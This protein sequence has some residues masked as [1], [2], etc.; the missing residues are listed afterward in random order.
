ME[1]RTYRGA[2]DPIALAQYLIDTWDQR[3]TAAQAMQGD[4]G[5]IVQVGQRTGGL[6]DDTPKQALTLAL[7]PAPEGLRVTMSQQQ[8]YSDSGGSIM[9]GGL[10][11]FFPF[12]FTW[13]LGGSRDQPVDPQL[14]AQLWQS[15][16]D[17]A[18]RSGAAPAASRPLPRW[19]APATGETVRL[20][21]V[22][23]PNCGTANPQGTARCRECGTFLQIRDC[24]Q[25][26]VSNPATANFCMR[27]GSPLHAQRAVGG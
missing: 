25:C 9:V 4:E 12:F 13:P 18:R 26:G 15:I 17:Y 22:T 3:D 20:D 19:P 27:C 7:E 1:Q 16:D 14:A 6:F 11:G 24:P 23:C 2:S 8:W 21:A 10:I 5:I